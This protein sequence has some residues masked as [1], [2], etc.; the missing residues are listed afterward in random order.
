MKGEG[1]RPRQHKSWPPF[2]L[3]NF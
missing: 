1:K 3:C 2:G